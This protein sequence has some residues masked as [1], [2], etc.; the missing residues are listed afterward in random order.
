[1]AEIGKLREQ[2]Q[3][4]RKRQQ[5]LE[6]N[7]HLQPAKNNIHA[8]TA[9]GSAVEG[10]TGAA[11][12][13]KG[14]PRKQLP[15]AGSTAATATP[16]PLETAHVEQPQL[17][18]AQRQEAQEAQEEQA[19]RL[20]V[21]QQNA[22]ADR[23]RFKALEKKAAADGAAAHA[24]IEELEG[25]VLDAAESLRRAKRATAKAEAAA[26]AASVDA[27]AMSS[28]AD[29]LAAA[30]TPKAAESD[31]RARAEDVAPEHAQATDADEKVGAQQV[32]ADDLPV[33]TLRKKHV[34]VAFRVGAA[35]GCFLMYLLVSR[36]FGAAQVKRLRLE[37]E[38]CAS[39]LRLRQEDGT[40]YAGCNKE[41]ER[42]KGVIRS[43]SQQLR[44]LQT[45]Y[46]AAIGGG[47]GG[48][49]DEAEI[50]AEGGPSVAPSGWRPSFWPFGDGRSMSTSDTEAVEDE[51]KG[52]TFDKSQR[53]RAFATYTDAT[54][55]MEAVLSGE[56]AEQELHT[57]K[58]E[59]GRVVAAQH[60]TLTEL[61]ACEERLLKQDA[62][63]A[64]LAATNQVL[65]EHLIDATDELGTMQ[66]SYVAM[67]ETSSRLESAHAT[68]VQSNESATNT[69][70]NSAWH[71]R[72]MTILSL[73]SRCFVFSIL[74]AHRAELDGAS[75]H[76]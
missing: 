64:S 21:L 52:S 6:Q 38:T 72:I 37:Q 32:V 11:S 48:G 8:S 45:E 27:R 49:G 41:L 54:A 22:A 62:W 61:T 73:L 29:V 46:A 70:G 7:K 2:Q 3:K 20:S 71:T 19:R 66:A 28:A 5:Q 25:Q 47:G 10:G 67:Q 33:F 50:N 59:R 65:N 55:M 16:P 36:S 14:F 69:V 40:L 74:H 18:A 39:Q 44:A 35:L 58:Q 1:M 53:M 24:R 42:E 43:L 9:P 13:R 26:K 60:T 12:S 75:T 23:S 30:T 17:S 31:G 51:K 68:L 56:A 4:Q 76:R 57:C 63:A 34:P 15:N